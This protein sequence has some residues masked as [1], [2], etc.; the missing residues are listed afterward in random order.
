MRFSKTIKLNVL[1]EFAQAAA[2]AAVAGGAP[3]KRPACGKH[4]TSF[5]ASF[6]SD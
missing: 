4:V 6:F 1:S 2:A 5:L 3:P